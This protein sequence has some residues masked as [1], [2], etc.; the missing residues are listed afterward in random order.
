MVLVGLLLGVFCVWAVTLVTQVDRLRDR[1]EARVGWLQTLTYL[2]GELHGGEVNAAQVETVAADLDDLAGEILDDRATTPALRDL[3]RAVVADDAPDS[4]DELGAR[5][6]GLVPAIRRETGMISVELGA[7]WDAIYRLTAVALLLA[8][9]TLASLIY[10]RYVV[11]QQARARLLGL[12]AHLQ[13]AD[14]LASVGTLA[15]G[16]AHE[17]NN[18]LGYAITSLQLAKEQSPDGELGELIDE[19]L[20]GAERVQGIVGDLRQVARPARDELEPCDLEDAAERSLKVLQ[21]RLRDRVT[22]VRDF[23]PIPPVLGSPARLEQVCLNLLINAADAMD[24]HP[25]DGAHTL[26]LRTRRLDRRHVALEIE[27]TGGGLAAE[28]ESKL[29]EPFVTSKPVGKG[30]GMGLFVS[31]N[32]IDALD[33]SITLENTGRGARARVILPVD[34][35]E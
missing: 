10:I 21:A 30:T 9:C 32:L 2:D 3:A 35:T 17:I 33:G 19:A 28:L 11:L 34:R 23:H 18:P 6:A 8:I 29:F 20:E 26:T 12:E 15:A 27:D 31:R 4:P 13:R 16:V 25:N 1:V 7:H 5:I 14:R 24:D 22:V